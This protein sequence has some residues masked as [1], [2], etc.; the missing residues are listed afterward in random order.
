MEKNRA[1]V[2]VSVT[3]VKLTAYG[4]SKTSLYDLV[5]ERLAV[6]MQYIPGIPGGR[7]TGRLLWA[8]CCQSRPH[9]QLGLEQGPGHDAGKPPRCQG[10]AA[11]GTQKPFPDPPVAASL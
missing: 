7:S 1:S 11:A 3:G 8:A 10:G 4:M 6:D 2:S 9:T 5:L